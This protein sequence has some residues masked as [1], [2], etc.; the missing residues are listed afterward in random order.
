MIRG[1]AL[2]QSLVP[3][4]FLNR[5]PTA[6]ATREV[7]HTPAHDLQ[8]VAHTLQFS[9]VRHPSNNASEAWAELGIRLD[10]ELLDGD[11]SPLLSDCSSSD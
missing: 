8:S 10:P 1:V 4:L 9:P 7:G 11:W 2:T 5:Q 6:R 3:T